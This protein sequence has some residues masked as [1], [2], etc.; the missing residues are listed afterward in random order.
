MPWLET[1][2]VACIDVGPRRP[3]R[4][5]GRRIDRPQHRLYRR[6]AQRSGA[7]RR[8]ARPAAAVLRRC[9]ACASATPTEQAA[10]EVK[11]RLP[12]AIDAAPRA[13]RRLER[14][15]ARSPGLRRGDDADSPPATSCRPATWTQRVLN[16][17]GPIKSMNG[18]ERMRAALASARLRDP[19]RRRLG[20]ASG[21]SIAS[22]RRSR[23]ARCVQSVSQASFGENYCTQP[24]VDQ[25]VVPSAAGL[26]RM[27]RAARPHFF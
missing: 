8:A 27:R 15:G 25:G 14:R 2:M 7:G 13:L 3:E 26:P 19:L 21:P 17:L 11:P 23:S 20:L 5:G 18:R 4:R 22:A 10:G 1:F 12:Q 6:H 16:R 24:L 9:S